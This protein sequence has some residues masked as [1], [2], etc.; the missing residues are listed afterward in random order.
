MSF[1]SGALRLDDTTPL[2]SR[3]WPK[4]AENA[5]RAPTSEELY[6]SCP[7]EPSAR[8]RSRVEGETRRTD[9]HEARTTVSTGHDPLSAAAAARALRDDSVRARRAALTAFA[10]AC[11]LI[12]VIRFVELLL[13]YKGLP[14]NLTSLIADDVVVESLRGT[15][16]YSVSTWLMMSVLGPIA[17]L[18]LFGAEAWKKRSREKRI[19]RMVG[20]A[21]AVRAGLIAHGTERDDNGKTRL[22]A[23]L[24]MPTG[25]SIPAVVTLPGTQLPDVESV[26]VW[27]DADELV[28]TTDSLILEGCVTRTG[29]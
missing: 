12:A 13:L 6:R 15:A 16:T 19:G 11:G 24:A 9:V 18:G 14:P 29:T 8:A 1:V 3:E 27:R 2:H 25:D 4:K 7:S 21:Q 20:Q 5:R 10:I 23:T 28:V 17:I 22:R 26:N